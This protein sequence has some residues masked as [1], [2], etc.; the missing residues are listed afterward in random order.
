MSALIANRHVALD[1]KSLD[2]LTRELLKMRRFISSLLLF[3]VMVSSPLASTAPRGAAVVARFGG[4]CEGAAFSFSLGLQRLIEESSRRKAFP[5]QLP[6][7]YSA[8]AYDLN[9]DGTKEYFVRLSCGGTGN[10]S[11]GIFSTRPARLRGIFT[12]WFFYIHRRAGSWSTLSTYTRE[13]GDQGEIATLMNRRGSY[14]ETSNRTEHGY[15]GNWQPFL[16]RM[17]VPKCN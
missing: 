17:G 10:C 16:K 9:G 11:W 13:G 14:V 4:E 12:A 15:P 3:G 5:A 8:F 1:N 7:G 2:A 6:F